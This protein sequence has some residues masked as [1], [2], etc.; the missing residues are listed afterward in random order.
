MEKNYFYFWIDKKAKGFTLIELIITISILVVLSSIAFLSFMHY[1]KSARNASR[2]LSITT[3][4]KWLHIFQTKVGSYPK[5]DDS[6]EIFANNIP[7]WYQGI[8]WKNVSKLLYMNSVSLDPYF[9]EP[10]TY[11]TNILNNKYQ[12]LSYSEEEF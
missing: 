11:G 12:I 8:L 9:Q 5:P 10:Y 3:I 4:E 6:F 2:V 7:L 1:A